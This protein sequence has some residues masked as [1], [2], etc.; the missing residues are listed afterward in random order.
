MH[1]FV[2]LL[3]TLSNSFHKRASMKGFIIHYFKMF[4]SSITK[5]S[6]VTYVMLNPLTQNFIVSTICHL[7]F[8]VHYGEQRTAPILPIRN[9]RRNLASLC[10]IELL[11]RAADLM[12]IPIKCNIYVTIPFT[13]IPLEFMSL[14]FGKTNL[15]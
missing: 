4:N 1:T 13:V 5:I 7:S 8:D 10:V 6:T 14:G 11:F 15:Y 12:R 2:L 9:C 3:L